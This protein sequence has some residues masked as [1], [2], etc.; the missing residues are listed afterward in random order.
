MKK[1]RTKWPPRKAPSRSP[2][3]ASTGS[4]GVR[5]GPP[6][7]VAGLMDL[8]RLAGLDELYERLER[9]R[10][11]LCGPRGRWQADRQ[12]YRHGYDEGCLVLG[13]RKIRLPKPRVRS[14]ANEELELPH[15]QQ[16]SQEDPL[17]DRIVEQLV[18]GISTRNY[19]RSLERNS[20]AIEDVATSRSSVSRR[21]VVQT[22]RRV[23]EFLSRPLDVY[24]LPVVMVDGTGFGDH[25][26]VVA[27]GIDT[28]GRKHVLGVAE[29]STESEAVVRG[30]FRNL[31]D[32]GLVVER[33]R[34][35]VIDGGKGLRKAI[36]T[37]FGNWARVHRCRQHKRKNVADHLPKSRR[38]WV[39]A[40]M[41]R[42]WQAETKKQGQRKLEDL[43]DQL[44]TDHPGAAASLREGLEETL[45][46]TSL[47]FING[48]LLQTLCTTNPIENLQGTLKKIARNVKRWRGGAMALRWAVTGLM[49]AEKTFRRVRGYRELP[50]LIAA[51]EAKMNEASLDSQRRVA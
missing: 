23:E 44:A 45:T 25:V 34:L 33:A 18:I 30:L 47:G 32:R 1:H 7:G 6:E 31:I 49:E 27:L 15:W 48:A 4:S 12:A 21:F 39:Q 35:F 26:I 16:F 17:N 38:A 3:L 29:G 24:D 50:K 43:V 8:F 5:R 10:E 13:G 28:D 51:I 14:R 2:R 11:A 9:D 40:V 46:L 37:T 41:N 36:R 22:S 42:A 19:P 20:G